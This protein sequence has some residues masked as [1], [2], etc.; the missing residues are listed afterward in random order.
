MATLME[1]FA[2]IL[3]VAIVLKFLVWLFFPSS[4]GNMANKMVGNKGLQ[5][6]YLALAVVLSWLVINAFGI[7]T[8]AAAWLAVAAFYG[9]VF[10]GFPK[11]M[12]A[13]S[14]KMIKNRNMLWPAWIY[15]VIIGLWVLW[16]LFL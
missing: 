11:E 16:T 12:K 5:A 3:A 8:F 9:Y 7:I 14:K 1:W 10:L 15:A 6:L 13:I 2:G 4:L